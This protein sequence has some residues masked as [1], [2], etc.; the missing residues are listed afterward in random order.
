M[1]WRPYYKLNEHGIES[2]AQQTYEP[3]ISD[4]EKTFCKNYSW[5]NEYQY[6][7]EKERPLYTEEVVDWFFSNE[8]RWIEYFKDSPYAPEIIDINLSEKKIYLKWYGKTC[9]QIIYGET[10]WPKDRWLK[11]IKDIILDQYSKGVYKLTMYPHCHYIDNNNNMR[12]IDWYG[13][14][15][16]NNPYIEEK[17]MEGI[18]HET[19]K[20]RLI[21]TGQPIKNLLNLETMF[22]RSLNKHVLWGDHDMSYIYR[23]MFNA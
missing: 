16:V 12:A 18:I 6:M 20:F 11:Q 7:Y 2:M 15:P 21:E 22:K 19:A 14:V 3:L 13:C 17:Y 1:N 4:D 10:S 8:L 23:E 5:P 9:N